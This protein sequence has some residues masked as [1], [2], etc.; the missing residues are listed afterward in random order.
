MMP[1]S[2]MNGREEVQWCDAMNE[3]GG[4]CGMDGDQLSTWSCD[5]TPPQAPGEVLVGLKQVET[6]WELKESS[7]GRW[8]GRGGE[9]QAQ[10][11]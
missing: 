4:I 11:C 10:I 7:N 5:A 8:I 3:L 1:A 9:G 2:R 6:N